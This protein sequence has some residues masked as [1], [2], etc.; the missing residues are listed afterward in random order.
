MKKLFIVLIVGL[1][2]SI[3]AED[4]FIV[5]SKPSTEGQNLWATYAQ[6]PIEA[7]TVYV[8]TYFSKEG[9]KV[10]YQRF[11]DFSFSSDGGRAI[12]D[13]SKGTLYKYSVS[14]Q[15]KK[16]LPKAKKIVKITVSLNELGT[17]AMYSESPGLLALHKAI[18]ASSYKS[19]F[20]WITAI[21]F[22]NKSLFKISVAFT[23]N[24]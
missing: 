17:G 10:I 15:K 14:L 9:S 23:D 19:G 1:V 4:V 6:I 7:V 13:F 3:F 24:M 8:P 20:A 21:Q 22:D 16:S 18:L 11:F 12:K 2:S 5:I